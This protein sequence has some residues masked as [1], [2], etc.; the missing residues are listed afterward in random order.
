M[1]SYYMKSTPLLQDPPGNCPALYEPGP[2][3]TCVVAP[4]NPPS[5][6][7]QSQISS[8]IIRI[9]KKSQT[10]KLPELK[11]MLGKLKKV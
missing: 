6:S 11:I 10:A 8:N 3:G 2:N 9:K 5:Q 7:A 4:Y 1:K